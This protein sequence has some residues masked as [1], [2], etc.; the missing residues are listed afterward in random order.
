VRKKYK[1]N[2]KGPI[3]SA[4][5]IIFSEDYKKVLIVPDMKSM[6]NTKYSLPG[7]KRRIGEGYKS[8]V[9]REMKE[10]SGLSVSGLSEV[11]LVE[12]RRYFENGHYQTFFT[13][14]SYAGNIRTKKYKNETGVPI[15]VSTKEALVRKDFLHFMHRFALAGAIVQLKI[16]ENHPDRAFDLYDTLR[17]VLSKD[18][19]KLKNCISYKPR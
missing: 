1:R 16:L 3:G 8:A 10:E 7:G 2:P 15:W 11:T 18:N 14:S 9:I 4:H 6:G 12:A 5:C 13:A 19:V 17:D